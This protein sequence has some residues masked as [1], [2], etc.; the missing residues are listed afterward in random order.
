MTNSEIRAALTE[1]QTVALTL[2]GEAQAMLVKGVGWRPSPVGARIDVACVLANR[3]RTKGRFGNSFKDVCLKPAAFSC[4]LADPTT[5]NDDVL[6]ALAE[7]LIL[8]GDREADVLMAECFWIADGVISGALR[9]QVKGAT[10]YF[11]E[12]MPKPPRWSVGEKAV[13][14]QHGHIF[15]AGIK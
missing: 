4:W 10:H 1:R 11:A 6:Y 3:V 7:R 8:F 14:H 15:F 5:P 9:D 12:W 2:R 13:A